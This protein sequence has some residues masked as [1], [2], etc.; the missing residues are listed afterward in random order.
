[1]KF[2]KRFGIGKIKNIIKNIAKEEDVINVQNFNDWF[3]DDNNRAVYANK[4]IF[5]RT[6][7]LSEAQ[8]LDY[9]E[10]RWG[11]DT[12]EYYSDD[13]R[14]FLIR[15]LYSQVSANWRQQLRNQ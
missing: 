15:A 12:F 5:L 10:K 7:K 14:H 1:M 2:L 4:G 6:D 13:E 3:V 11:K 8:I 9:I